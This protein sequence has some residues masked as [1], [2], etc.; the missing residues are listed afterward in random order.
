[1]GQDNQPKHRQAGREIKRQQARRGMYERVLIVC[2]G[3]KTEP[4]YLNEIRAHYRLQ[5]A[6]VVVRASE[7]GTSPIQVAHYAEQLF[8][9]GDPHQRL[10]AREFDRVYVVFDRDDHDTYEEALAYCAEQSGRWRNSEHQPVKVHAVASVPC[11]ELWLLLHFEDV[12]APLHRNEVYERLKKHMPDY[13]K[14]GSGFWKRTS[15]WQPD[16]QRRAG[17]LAKRTSAQDGI[18]PFTGMA[19]L[20]AYLMQ[21]RENG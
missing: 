10:Q 15:Q 9:N 18:Q 4:N 12:Q 3:E 19:E 5:T 20:V 17:E 2:E 7:L 14:G 11:F 16:A 21:I 6:N 13:D 1:V 8:K